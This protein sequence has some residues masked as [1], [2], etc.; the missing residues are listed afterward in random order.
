M[1]TCLVTATDQNYLMAT[2]VMLR[3]VDAN[4]KG[5]E[6][7]DVYILVSEKLLGFTF[8]DGA[9]KNL[10]IKMVSPE[11]LTAPETLTAIEKMYGHTTRITPASMYRFFVA[12]A[13]PQYNRAVYIDPDTL[14]ARDIAPLLNFE[15]DPHMGVAA[16]PEIQ[17]ELSKNESFKDSPYFNSGVMVINLKKWR[18]SKASKYLLRLANTFQDWT[19][20]SDQDVLNVYLK[21][22]WTPLPISFN[23]LIN[24]YP[25]WTI[26]D[27]LVVHWAGQRKPWS[28]ATND[29]WRILWKQYRM[30]S[31]TTVS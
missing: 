4:Y 2:E 19:G 8:R 26:E 14:I 1:E 20:A 21:H 13:I 15:L 27:P 23:Y 17:I 5:T 6:K 9:F 28:N 16:L 3:S 30:Q 12:D 22:S 7:L 31:P 18:L 11:G 29:K 25:D 10:N 24:V